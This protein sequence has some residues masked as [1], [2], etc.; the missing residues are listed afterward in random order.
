MKALIA[1]DALLAYPDHNQPFDIET[2]ASDLQLG[3]VINQNKMVVLFLLITLANSPLP[4]ATTWRLKRSSLA[5][6]K[7]FVS[8]EPCYLEPHFVCTPITATW[9]TS[10]LLSLLSVSCG[11]A[12]YS[13]NMV[14]P[15]II[16][17]V[18]KMW[19]LMLF[20]VFPLPCRL[21]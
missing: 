17:L 16:Y 7:L 5:L 8:F 9:P 13:K 12:F 21:R 10:W 20:L 1:S 2:D 11:G 14:P 3:A 18:P 15:S 6:L 19:L 4:N